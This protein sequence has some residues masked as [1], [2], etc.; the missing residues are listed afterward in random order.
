V[1]KSV[2]TTSLSHA[3]NNSAAL[4]YIVLLMAIYMY[5]G[6][7]SSRLTA[8]IEQR[9]AVLYQAQPATGATGS[10]AAAAM[11]LARKSVI[12]AKLT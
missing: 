2:E 9:I 3:R 7:F 8:E 12:K 1:R 10:R 5:L 11:A 4:R 6:P